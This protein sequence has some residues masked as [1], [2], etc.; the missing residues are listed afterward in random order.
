MKKIFLLFFAFTLFLIGCAK[1]NWQ[2]VY[3]PDGCLVCEDKYI[4]SPVF[5]TIEDCWSWGNNLK[6]SKNNPADLFECGKNCKMD[7]DLKLLICDD[8]K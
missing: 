6:N 1:I 2:G 8:T 4:F 7:K 3:Y 5:P